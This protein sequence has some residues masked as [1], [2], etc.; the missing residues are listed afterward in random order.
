MGL[1]ERE[2][3]FHFLVNFF[4]GLFKPKFLRMYCKFMS[5]S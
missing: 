2:E 1:K 5:K 4:W 3:N